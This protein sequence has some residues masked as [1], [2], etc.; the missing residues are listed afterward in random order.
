MLTLIANALAAI[1]AAYATGTINGDWFSWETTE[2]LVLFGVAM[3]VI[4][5]IIKPV[6]RLITIPLSCLTFGLF[7]LVLNALL[8]ALGA[9]VVPGIT[10]TWQGAALGS[11]L[12]SLASGIIFS[13]LND[14]D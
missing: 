12:L 13:V 7:A 5:A 14:H 6:A 8:F 2:H 3:G 10:V 9:Q 4:N 1:V 11:L